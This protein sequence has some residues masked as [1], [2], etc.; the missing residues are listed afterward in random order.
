MIKA[1]IILLLIAQAAPAKSYRTRPSRETHHKGLKKSRAVMPK[2][3]KRAGEVTIPDSMDLR[4]KIS[5]I[6]D[7]G[8]CGS[9]YAFATSSSLR[10]GLMIMGIDPGALSPQYLMDYSGYGCEGGYFD[11]INQAQDPKKDSLEADY[12]YLARDQRPRAVNGK[13]GSLVS[14]G[15]LGDDSVTPK[16]IEEFMAEHGVPVPITMA[17]GAGDFEA[18]SDGIYDGCVYGQVDHM[19]A[20]VG[21]SNEG[22]KFLSNGFL[23]PGKGYW[24]VRNSWKTVWGEQGF[25]RIRMTDSSGRKCNNVAADAAGFFFPKPSPTPSPSPSPSPTVNPVPPPPSVPWWQ[26]VINWIKG[27]F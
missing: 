1:L 11:V 20:V 22:E 18:Y 23:P 17:A 24:I 12:P 27:L 25:F 10:D 19:V 2:F 3:P 21:Y 15:M 14:W 8:Q 16:D 9:C 7:Q 5:P 26:A 4:G 6:R 13:G